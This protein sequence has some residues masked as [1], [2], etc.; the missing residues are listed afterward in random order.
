M[1]IV[2]L[3]VGTTGRVNNLKL[4]EKLGN[5]D[6]YDATEPQLVVER[7][8]GKEVIITNKVNITREVIDRLPDLRLICVAATGVDNVDTAYA[9]KKGIEV[10]NVSG[11]STD[12]VAQVTF[13]MLLHLVNRL[14]YYDDYVKSGAYSRN[15]SFTHHGKP[16]WELRGKRIGIIGLGTIGRQVA[17]IAE[18]FGMEVVFYSASGRNNHI[19]YKRFELNDLLISSDVVSIH[20]PLTD[21]TR[22]LITYE[23]M[24][25]MRPCAVLLNLG[26]GGI[27]NE[28]DLARALNENL[29]GAA[30][31]DVME[32]EPIETG[33]PLLK[34]YNR[35]KLLI[36]PHMA[37]ASRESRELL[38]EK[39]AGNIEM[40]RENKRSA[41]RASGN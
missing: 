25:L 9:K 5:L 10:K 32:H 13:A 37:W 39:I 33:N 15:P 1:E 8:T 30:G 28:S 3:D 7:C 29:I 18:S 14:S 11:Y 40:Y 38:L 34:I 23:K 19:S 26:R 41:G 21:R 24:K 4:I 2:F 16:F 6:L 20:A 36:T 22:N 35:D 31:I 27:I 17:R 12:S